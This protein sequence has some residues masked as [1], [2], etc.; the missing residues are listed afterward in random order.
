M[1]LSKEQKST[2]ENLKKLNSDKK[3][4][5][6]FIKHSVLEY[7]FKLDIN[8][9]SKLLLVYLLKNISLDLRHLYILTPYEKLVKE[10]GLSKP[11]IVKCLKELNSKNIIKLHSGTN[12]EHNTKIKAFIFEREQ[13][14]LYTPNQHN[15]CELTTFFKTYFEQSKEN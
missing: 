8:A 4:N 1:E 14:K 3:T 10:L 15:I 12:K 7:I 5:Y 6:L 13:F 2:I 9:S 11:T